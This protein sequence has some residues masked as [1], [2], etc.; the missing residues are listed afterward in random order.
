MRVLRIAFLGQ[1][2]HRKEDIILTLG[3]IPSDPCSRER[4]LELGLALPSVSLSTR[5]LAPL[6][7][8]VLPSL[9]EDSPLDDAVPSQH[10]LVN[11]RS[12]TSLVFL[13]IP[14][15]RAHASTHRSY[16][17]RR[18]TPRVFVPRLCAPRVALS[19]SAL[20]P[21]CIPR[22]VL[23]CNARTPH[24]RSGGLSFCRGEWAG[25]CR[26]CGPSG[27]IRWFLLVQDELAAAVERA[28]PRCSGRTLSILGECVWAGAF[29]RC[30]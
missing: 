20:A 27:D 8:R 29:L 17:S 7:P 10:A 22:A 30:G 18:W 15:R 4:F 1:L 24:V 6:A 9:S 2:S 23:L 13:R 5:P 12:M 19:P 28:W 26:I 25:L 14:T 3:L 21:H 11:T 16:A